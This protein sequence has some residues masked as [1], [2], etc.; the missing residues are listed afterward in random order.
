[1]NKSESLDKIAAALAEFQENMPVVPKQRVGKIE[2]KS[3]ASGN[4][5]SYEYKYSDLGDAVEAA[6]P[7]LANAGLS[8]TQWV[9]YE[10]GRDVLTTVVMHASGQWLEGTMRLLIPEQALSPQ[11]QGSATSYGRRYS[12][13][14]ALGI[15]ADIDDDGALAQMAYGEGSRQR[16][17]KAAPR[18]GTSPARSQK[19][20][21]GPAVSDG[22]ISTA[23]VNNIRRYYAKRSIT[24][25]EDICV[26]CE[27]IIGHEVADLHALTEDEAVVILKKLVL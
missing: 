16:T 4:E 27:A 8:V 26:E 9:G 24:K 25:E 15:V 6:K 7:H 10:D 18:Q 1:M 17:R 23:D 2:G 13:C 5:Y 11:V 22:K 19:P 14:A 3:K 21:A 20:P 12:F